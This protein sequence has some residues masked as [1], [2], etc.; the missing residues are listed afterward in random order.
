LPRSLRVA[1]CMC[2]ALVWENGF[3]VAGLRAGIA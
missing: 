1:M 3:L 2:F